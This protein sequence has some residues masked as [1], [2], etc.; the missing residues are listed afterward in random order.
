MRARLILLYKQNPR[1]QI[2]TLTL[3]ASLTV[4]NVINGEDRAIK[5]LRQQHT[6]DTFLR[7]NVLCRLD[8]L[9]YYTQKPF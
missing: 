4:I 9:Y 7:A 2:M 5:R 1:Q 8:I 3:G 6:P